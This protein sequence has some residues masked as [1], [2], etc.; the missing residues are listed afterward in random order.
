MKNFCF[1]LAGILLMFNTLVHADNIQKYNIL[2]K[3]V[4]IDSSKKPQVLEFFSFFCPH[5]YELESLYHVKDT[6]KKNLSKDVKIKRYHVDFIG[7]DLGPIATHAWAIAMVLGI[8]DK[9]I[10]NIFDDV[11]KKNIITDPES[12]KQAFIKAASIS[13]KDYDTAWDSF[14]VKALVAQQQKATLDID[15]KGVPIFLVN[16]KYMINNHAIN[17][18]NV[19]H[20][21]NNYAKVAKFLIKKK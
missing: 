13:S 15:L 18:T 11:Q 6:I 4:Y 17:V 2:S 21:A 19:N 9:I 3:P 1:F 5:C 20:I 10:L 7:D 8:E 16:G 14:I 12:L